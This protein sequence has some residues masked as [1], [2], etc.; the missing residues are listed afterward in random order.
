MPAA[1]KPTGA[2]VR[3]LRWSD[4]DPL[5]ESYYL[6]YDERRSN[7]TIGIGLFE[8]MPDHADEADWFS[9]LYRR[10]LRGETIVRV[11]E[12]DDRVVGSCV[13]GRVGPSPTSETGHRGVLGILVHRDFRGRGVGQG[14]LT[15]TIEAC[16]GRFDQIELQVFV[17]NTGARRLYERFGFVAVGRLPAAI[18]RNGQYLDEDL[19]VLDLRPSPAKR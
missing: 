19:M 2:V 11:A 3:E 15:A 12:L 6:L 10:M 8:E 9:G 17:A 7:P 5:R 4:F 13:V 16:R 14:L 1:P 18:R